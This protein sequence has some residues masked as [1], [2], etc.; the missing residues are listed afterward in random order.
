LD[1]FGILESE[2]LQKGENLPC[3]VKCSFTIENVGVPL[4]LIALSQRASPVKTTDD[5]AST[6][7]KNPSYLFK[8]SAYIV[9]K[10]DGGNHEDKVE[11]LALEGQTL[12][13]RIVHV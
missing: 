13:N 2:P 10:A 4:L 1:F 12:S 3:L 11:L 9:Q 8:G 7:F 6:L 5:E